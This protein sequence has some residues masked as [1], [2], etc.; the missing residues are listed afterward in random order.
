MQ[1]KQKA[2]EA[3]SYQVTDGLTVFV[4]P[5]P[6]HGYL[7]T[8]RQVANG[9]DVDENSIRKHL[10]RRAD[11]FTEGKHYLRGVNVSNIEE[12]DNLSP[13]SH[14]DAIFWTK[15]GV[16]RLG[17]TA[18]GERARLF[19]DWAEELIINQTEYADARLK[20]L[21]R[22]AYIL[23]QQQVSRQEDEVRALF[24]GARNNAGNFYRLYKRPEIQEQ[25]KKATAAKER[26]ER[27]RKAEQAKERNREKKAGEAK[28]KKTEAFRRDIL[29]DIME[30][31]DKDL[32]L[33]IAG[34][35]MKNV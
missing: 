34:K 35:L 14:P 5:A 30:I 26:D 17:F 27:R 32:R 7:M 19:R 33:R 3:I 13:L 21:D 20:E 6:E 15:R 28:A 18:R 12:G 8:T 16:I 11:E 29:I 31:E 25:A 24:E 4:H 9:Y 23:M 1:D 22:R 10:Q 2:I